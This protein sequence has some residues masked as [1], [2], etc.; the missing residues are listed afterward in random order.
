M[1]VFCWLGFLC[2][3][4]ACLGTAHAQE[5][6]TT[7][8]MAF[9]D[10]LTVGTGASVGYPPRLNSML[11]ENRGPSRVVNRGRGGETTAGGLSRLG[12]VLAQD[13]PDVVLLMEGIN[14]VTS[15]VSQG[16]TIGNLEA[17]IN[18]AKGS[19]AR[20]LLA[21][22]PPRGDVLQG[23]NERLNAQINAL[24]GRTGVTLVDMEDA[25]SRSNLAD[26]VH[27]NDAGYQQMA[28][29]WFRRIG[30]GGG[31]GGGGCFV[32][33]AVYGDA[34][35][36]QVVRFRRFRD[37]YLVV[38]RTGRLMVGA[39]YRFG[40]GTARAVA[41]SAELRNACRQLLDFVDRCIRP[42]P[43]IEVAD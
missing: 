13:R 20:V 42:L 5:E 23:A 37:R 18:L 15:Q 14:D 32:A 26:H 12:G 39:Y 41:R 7:V 43:S 36:P 8:Y 24:A 27:Y 40:P 31:G 30:G 6:E 28:N 2:L 29:A 9:G 33:T 19:G 11:N 16:A 25:V 34:D 38:T 17:M 10:S 1:R 21:T 22:L 4:L 35:A 3:C